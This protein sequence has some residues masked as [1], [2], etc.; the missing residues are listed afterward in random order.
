MIILVI[1]AQVPEANRARFLEL[2]RV[3]A[4]ASRQED[5]GCLAFDVYEVDG[6]PGL[7]RFF[8]LWASLEDLTAHRDYA[9]SAAFREHGRPLATS[10]IGRKFDATE[11]S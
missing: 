5:R 2:A 4:E 6:T 1:E 8:E 11:L 7:V 10:L 9:H 3:H